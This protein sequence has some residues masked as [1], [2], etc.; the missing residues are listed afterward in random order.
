[1]KDWAKEF[2]QS[3]AWRDTRQAY[4]SYRHHLCERCNNTA[5]I[6]HHIKWL[7]PYNIGNVKITLDWSN[8]QCVCRE[9]HAMIHEGVSA[10]VAG[11]R[12]DEAG[13]VV[14]ITQKDK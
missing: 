8:L 10:T 1:M 13:N 3:R 11:L 14:R 9:C 7:N 5:E 4:L 2:Y 12:F 6:V